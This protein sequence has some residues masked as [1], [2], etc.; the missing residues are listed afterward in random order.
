MNDITIREATIN[1]LPYINDLL[2][3]AII[4]T[5]YNLS[6]EPRSMEDA[7]LWFKTH[8]DRGY[9]VLVAE[10]DGEVIGWCS[11]SEFRANSGYKPTAEISV[12]ISSK[13]RHKGVGTRLIAE[14][15]RNSEHYHT[16]V[17]VVTDNNSASIALFTRCGFSPMF[18][19]QEVGYKNG[20]Y[21]SVTFMVKR[22]STI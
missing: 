1:D 7:K 10:L 11:F 5:N 17:A 13:H 21:R 8:V 3:Y 16:L 6:L 9:L 15:E 4:H 14:L 2:N 22:T 18:T 19:F 20:K 12:Y